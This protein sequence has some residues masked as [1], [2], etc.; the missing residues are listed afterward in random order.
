[1]YRVVIKDK[2]YNS[3]A[4]KFASMEEVSVFV[5]TVLRCSEHEIEVSIENWK[6]EAENEQC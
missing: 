4:F 1:M 5:E 2:N 6:E 3:M